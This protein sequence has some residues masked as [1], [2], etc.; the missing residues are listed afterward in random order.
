MLNRHSDDTQ[1][2]SNKTTKVDDLF[3]ISDS[4]VVGNKSHIDSDLNLGNYGDKKD[5]SKIIDL[6][7]DVFLHALKM[8]SSDIHIEPRENTVKI[9]FRVD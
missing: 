3:S 5:D 2:P 8:K 6:V 4:S 7:N 1:S 9:R